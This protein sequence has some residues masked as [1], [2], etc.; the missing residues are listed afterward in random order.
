M[1]MNPKEVAKLQGKGK[2]VIANKET[3][4]KERISQCS[5]CHEETEHIRIT[6]HVNP[7]RSKYQCKS[8]FRTTVKCFDSNCKAMARSQRG[9]NEVYCFHHSKYYKEEPREAHCSWCFEETTHILYMDNVV[10]RVTRSDKIYSCQ[11]CFKITKKCTKCKVNMTRL[12]GLNSTS[13]CFECCGL[14][15]SNDSVEDCIKK[16]SKTA[17]CPWCISSTSHQLKEHYSTRSDLYQCGKCLMETTSCNSCTGTMVKTSS[18]YSKCSLCKHN[19]SESYWISLQEKHNDQINAFLE[20]GYVE[21]QL[22]RESKYKQKARKAGLINPFLV[23]VSMHPDM[24]SAV[25]FK[26]QIHLIKKKCYGDTHAESYKILFHKKKGIQRRSNTVPENIGFNDDANWYQILRR[27]IRD[28]SGYSTFASAH[29]DEVQSECL[30]P[31]SELINEL[32]V[33]LLESIAQRHLQML[34]CEIREKSKEIYYSPE[35]HQLFDHARSEGMNSDSMF[36]VFVSIILTQNLGNFEDLSYIKSMNNTEFIEYLK[37]NIQGKNATTNRLKRVEKI[38]CV[39]AIVITKIIVL[40]TI[41]ELV[42]F[43]I[44]PP[45]GPAIEIGF[46]AVAIPTIVTVLLNKGS[47]DISCPAIILIVLQK[48]LLAT[49]HKIYL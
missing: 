41:A 3:K 22:K 25:A 29:H 35:I 12:G 23:L 36:I 6:K 45:L 21:E 10:N 27:A 26:L 30:N 5:W 2:Q 37:R 49:A 44:F 33:E 13:Q 18:F 43:F 42:A 34:P 28:V 4:L 39:T 19:R 20:E 32:E 47:R 16:T 11:S 46:L 7:K 38:T 31:S 14:V 15:K 40:K 1:Y 17:W 8:C 48:F 24:R 9:W